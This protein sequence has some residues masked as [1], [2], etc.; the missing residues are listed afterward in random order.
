MYKD[1]LLG[2]FAA[3][4]A[5]LF[6]I[7]NYLMKQTMP[8]TTAIE[9]VLFALAGSLF[10]DVDIKSKGQKLFYR[11]IVALILISLYKNNINLAVYLALFSI[12]PVLVRHRGLFH[13]VWFVIALP[14]AGAFL[15]TSYFP[16]YRNALL[17]DA[18]FF[19]VGALS[20]LIMDFGYKGFIRVR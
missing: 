2:G 18:S 9:W 1:H 12:L 4:A 13:T 6:V 20:H 8:L 16:L 10:P 5:L 14:S 15:A 19:I 7:S 17:Y 3:G 11:L